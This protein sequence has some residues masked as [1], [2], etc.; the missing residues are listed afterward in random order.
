MEQN[1]R[2]LKYVENGGVF[3]VQ[4]N[5]PL[6]WNRTQYGPYQSRIVDRKHRVTDENSPMTILMPEHRIFHYP[7]KI[8]QQDFSHWVQERGLYFIQDRDKQF[9][10]LLASNDPGESPL[11][12]GLLVANFGKGQY[13]LTSYSWFRQLPAGVVGAIRLFT[14]LVSLGIPYKGEVH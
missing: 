12:G 14:N 10:A 6:T 5:T 1:I 4:Y 8:T 7:N 11:D 13:V 9:K 3:I 2:L